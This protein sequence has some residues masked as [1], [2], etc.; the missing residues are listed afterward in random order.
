VAHKGQDPI[1]RLFRW[2]VLVLDLSAARQQKLQAHPTFL[3]RGYKKLTNKI[4]VNRRKPAK[5]GI[6]VLI[7]LAVMHGRSSFQ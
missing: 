5:Q 7:E 6:Q 4:Y 3:R 1:M 2:A